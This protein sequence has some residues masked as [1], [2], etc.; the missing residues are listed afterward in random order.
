[1]FSI[2]KKL[3]TTFLFFTTR[4]LPAS[5]A[6]VSEFIKTDQFGYKTAD[7][8]IA[9]ISDPQTGYNATLSFT[10][11]TTYEI[12]DWSTDAVVFTGTITNWNAGATHSQ[13]GDKVYW[14]D[15]STLTTEGI[16]YVFDPTNNVGSYQFE[17]NDCIYNDVLITA[18]RMF[19]Y[20]RCW[21]AN[22]Y[23]MQMSVLQMEQVTWEPSRILIVGYTIIPLLLH[24]RIFQADGMMRVIIINM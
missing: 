1:M 9:I 13:S 5:P 23:P 8:K 19:Y 7:Q 14:F 20:Q 10:P 11:G 6:T 24:Q 16:Y 15:F 12:R 17:I 4:L 18:M 3:F 2:Y 21:F 22:N